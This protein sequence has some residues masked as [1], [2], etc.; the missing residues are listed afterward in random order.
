MNNFKLKVTYSWW[1][2]KFNT[3]EKKIH[4]KQTKTGLL[5]RL[6]IALKFTKTGQIK[7][8]KTLQL[9][10]NDHDSGGGKNDQRKRQRSGETE[11]NSI[12]LPDCAASPS[13]ARRKYNWKSNSY[14]VSIDKYLKI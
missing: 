5:L 4:Q 14:N 10:N 3:I 2:K 11:K 7:L 12:S 9:R 1:A 6:F 13:K 8:C